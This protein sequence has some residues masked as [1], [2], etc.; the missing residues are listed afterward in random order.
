VIRS[1]VLFLT[2]ADVTGLGIT[3]PEVLGVIELTLNE[4]G[5]GQVQMPPKGRIVP[6]ANSEIEAMPAF[7][8]SQ[9][10]LGMKWV[11]SFPEN[12]RRQLP[13]TTALLVMNDVAT[14]VPKVIMDATW[15]TAMRTGAVTA[16]SAKHLARRDSRVLGVIGC[17]TQGRSNLLALD[18]VLPIEEV[19]VFDIRSEAAK[20]YVHDM[21]A[22]IGKRIQALRSPQQVVEGADV[23]IT[24]TASLSRPSPSIKD[25]WFTAGALAMPLDGP[26]L[27]EP[28]TIM[29]VDKFVCDTWTRI[30]QKANEG[31]FPGGLPKL[32]AEVGEIV[33]GAKPGRE[34]FD[35]RIMV[36]NTGMAI[37]D[38]ALGKL[39]HKRAVERGVGTVLRLL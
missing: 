23:V 16:I 22:T 34:T 17:G 27:W 18:H 39:I 11:G 21:T 26:S 2:S 8:P 1:E 37:E 14:G 25:G 19:R 4:H 5:K 9:G 20:D 28:R 6:R 10:A 24:A 7:I 12:Y 36:M 3:M 38:V 31:L 30:E 32:H 35:E 29:S 15:I 13:Q 33:A